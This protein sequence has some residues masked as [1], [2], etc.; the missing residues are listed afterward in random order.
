MSDRYN[1]GLGQQ[2]P[3][4]VREYTNVKITHSKFS[5]KFEDNEIIH[6]TLFFSR[7]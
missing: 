5:V 2:P 6:K 3:P 1:N 4:T 7:M